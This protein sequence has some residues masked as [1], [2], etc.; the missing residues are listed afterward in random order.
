MSEVLER[1]LAFW[2]G[3]VHDRAAARAMRMHIHGLSR[4]MRGRHSIYGC[5][6]IYSGGIVFEEVSMAQGSENAQVVLLPYRYATRT[7]KRRYS[8]RDSC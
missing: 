3:D 4:Y 6:L 8:R 7:E 1:W 5:Q 2:L